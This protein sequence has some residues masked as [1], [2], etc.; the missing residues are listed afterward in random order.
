MKKDSRRSR[1]VEKMFQTLS[2][3]ILCAT[4][5]FSITPIPVQSKPKPATTKKPFSLGGEKLPVAEL[6]DWEGDVSN[7]NW[8]EI[9]QV[10]RVR[11]LR[12]YDW[13]SAYNGAGEAERQKKR[14]LRELKAAGYAIT[15]FKW[16]WHSSGYPPTTGFRA[17]RGKETLSAIWGSNGSHLFLYWG[18]EVPQTMAR[19]RD[20][21]LIA[22]AIGGQTSEVEKLLKSGANSSAVDY[23]GASVLMLAVVNKN[24]AI[25]EQL[26]AALKPQS[27]LANSS[28]V[29]NAFKRASAQNDLKMVQVFLDAGVSPRQIDEAFFVA[30]TSFGTTEMT[31]KLLPMA[32]SEAVDKAL[33]PAAYSG[34]FRG[35]SIQFPEV[36][37]I[38]LKRKP[39]QSALNAAL[40][41]ASQNDESHLVGVLLMAGAD[42]ETRDSE[43]Q[44]VLLHA[45]RWGR[46]LN[47]DMKQILQHGANPNAR[48]NAGNT[49]LMWAAIGEE[50]LSNTELLLSRGADPKVRN[51]ARQT[52]I[53]WVQQKMAKL[54]ASSREVMNYLQTRQLLKMALETRRN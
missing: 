46:V 50:S 25:A 36:V 32:S 2:R 22:A 33:I 52:A 26:L 20:D 49:V 53:D 11:D 4:L 54:P 7:N 48:D 15:E 45:A 21:K 6:S 5:F 13:R 16:D 1:R 35:S 27:S 39:S 14:T 17:R 31:R 19:Q 30:A 23:A 38:L 43:G 12:V 18:H 40:I 28:N 29:T 24:S 3:F 47:L 42:V 9:A 8:Q 44:T 10:L 41:A 34:D 51:K 37:Q